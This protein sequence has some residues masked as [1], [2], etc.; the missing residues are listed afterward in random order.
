MPY[1][2]INLPEDVVPLIVGLEVPFPTWVAAQLRHHAA[3]RTRMSFGQQV[4]ADAGPA[5]PAPMGAQSRLLG[6][7]MERSAP[8]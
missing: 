6:E 8:W 4:L 3:P 2:T 7:R 1:L 5:G